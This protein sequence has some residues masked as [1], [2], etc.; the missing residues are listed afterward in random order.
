M[1]TLS[2]FKVTTPGP[3]RRRQYDYKNIILTTV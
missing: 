1:H 3:I 2:G